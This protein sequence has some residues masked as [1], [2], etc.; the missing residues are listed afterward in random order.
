M[1]SRAQDNLHVL[2]NRPDHTLPR[3]LRLLAQRRAR[4]T[5]RVAHHHAATVAATVAATETISVIVKQKTLKLFGKT[6]W[7]R[8]NARLFYRS[9]TITL[10]GWQSG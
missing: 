9:N 3:H 2:V 1:A 5:I 8:Y 10:E 6:S 7:H 4:T